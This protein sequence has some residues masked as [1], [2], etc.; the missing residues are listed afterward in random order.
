[1]RALQLT[2]LAGPKALELVEIPEPDRPEDGVVIDVRAAGLSFADLLFTRG[3]YQIRPDPP[4]VPG[5]EVAGVVRSAPAGSRLKPGQRVGAQSLL[6]AC[7]E[8][9]V[10]YEGLVFPLPDE[11][12][13]AAAIALSS[14]YLT[15]YLALQTRIALR[16]GESVLIHGAAGGVGSAAIQVTKALGGT[17]IA[18]TSSDTKAKLAKTA[19][20]DHVLRTDEDRGDALRDLGID[21]VDVVFDPVGGDAFQQSLRCVAQ[22]G[23]VAVIGFTSGTIPTLKVNQVL[24]KNI[25]I[26]G[27]N[28]TQE[29]IECRQRI[30]QALTQMVRDGQIAPLIGATYELEDARRALEDLAS[31]RAQ[32]K[33]VIHIR[34]QS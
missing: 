11:V 32:G 24:L 6:G 9:A 13:D 33:L 2:S 5:T 7:A 17:A 34:R 10:T 21:S 29:S 27:V 14:N 1:M 8:V 15:A 25:A 28:I 12:S 3:E 18:V 4:F 31:R 23:R 20:A 26:V 30:W 22:H 16:P 19:G